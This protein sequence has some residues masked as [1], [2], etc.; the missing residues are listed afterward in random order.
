MRDGWIDITGQCANTISVRNGACGCKVR[1]R[2]VCMVNE[3]LDIVD[4]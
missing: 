1:W 2:G 3:A 4:E